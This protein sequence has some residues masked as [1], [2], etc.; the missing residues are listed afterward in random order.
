MNIVL[1][2]FFL[3]TPLKVLAMTPLPF[4]QTQHRLDFTPVK[5][6]GKPPAEAGTLHRY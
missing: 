1:T 5:P 4:F 6:S 3:S 2:P